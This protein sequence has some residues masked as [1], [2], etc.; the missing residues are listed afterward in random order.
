MTPASLIIVSRHRPA[1]LVRALMAV[2]QM[3][4]PGFEV[5]VVADP[6]GVAAARATGLALKL[7]VF[8]QANISAARNIGLGM[9]AA[10]VVAFLDDD[11]VPEPTW[12]T[13]LTAPFDDN[14]VTAAGGFVLGRSG[15]AWQW[16]AAFVDA[17][18]FD[19]PF[20]TGPAVSLHQDTP[21][22]LRLSR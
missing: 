19:H 21:Q 4:H 3:D 12:L 13:R 8:D 7:A 14:R 2:A 16:R 11:A 1:A 15:L 20:D 5:I 10:P 18:G 17:G 6:A 9:A 22:Q